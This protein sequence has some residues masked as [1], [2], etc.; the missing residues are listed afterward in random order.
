MEDLSYSIQHENHRYIE[1]YTIISNDETENMI[2]INDS[3]FDENLDIFKGFVAYLH[4]PMNIIP[5]N[6]DKSM[7]NKYYTLI[8]LK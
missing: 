3:S 5:E 4:H 2:T 1:S 6:T 8:T 7:A